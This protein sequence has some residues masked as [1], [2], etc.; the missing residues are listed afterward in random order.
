VLIHP[1]ELHEIRRLWRSESGDWADSVPQIV[2][3]TLG[4]DLDWE[5]EDSVLYNTQDFALLDRICK[6]HELP[7]ELMV[8]LIG[9]EKASHGLKRRHNIHNQLSKVLN[10]EWRDLKTI[11]SDRNSDLTIDDIIETEDEE[12]SFAEEISSGQLDLLNNA[13]ANP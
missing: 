2:K 3:S 9:V 11:L 6:E 8:K 5:I 4:I 13:G 12:A 7:T 10:E 1:A